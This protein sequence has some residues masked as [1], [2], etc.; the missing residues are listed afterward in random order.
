MNAATPASARHKKGCNC[1][2][3]HCLKKYCECFEGG[4]GCSPS[5][6]CRECRNSF[7]SSNVPFLLEYGS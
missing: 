5:C 7:G 6:R 1:R 3:S 2:K 4:V